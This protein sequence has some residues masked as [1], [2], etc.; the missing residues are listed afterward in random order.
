[1]S[2]TPTISVADID[3]TGSKSSS[4][5]LRGDGTWAVP[6]GGTPYTGTIAK[7]MTADQSINSSTTLTNVTDLVFAIGASETWVYEFRI[8][9]W[10]QLD[11]TGIKLHFTVPAGASVSFSGY[12]LHDDTSSGYSL[13]GG[14]TTEQNGDPLDFIPAGFTYTKGV[15]LVHAVVVNSTTA[16]NVQLQFAQSTSDATNLTFKAKSF[17]VGIKCS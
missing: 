12:P 10:A 4:T 14:G 7:V 9:A 17:G 2:Y 6:S 5:F 1:M 13:V 8:I 15:V 16:G 3:A 11:L